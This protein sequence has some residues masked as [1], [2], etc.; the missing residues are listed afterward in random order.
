MANASKVQVEEKVKS[1]NDNYFGYEALHLVSQGIANIQFSLFLNKKTSTG[2]ILVAEGSLYLIDNILTGMKQGFV[3]SNAM[4]MATS[5]GYAIDTYFNTCFREQYKNTTFINNEKSDACKRIQDKVFNSSVMTARAN[6]I[7]LTNKY[8][9]FE[10][11]YVFRLKGKANNT[12][13]PSVIYDAEISIVNCN[14]LQVG[15]VSKLTDC[16]MMLSNI[17]SEQMLAEQIVKATDRVLAG[18]MY[19]G[20]MEKD[21]RKILIVDRDIVI[22]VGDGLVSETTK[23]YQVRFGHIS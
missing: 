12:P 2:S 13:I 5:K 18:R 22:E 10:I 6:K 19:S 7:T 8:Q 15:S 16:V 23:S 3:L 9:G 21:I 11:S 14:N 4:N 1:I 20:I 17:D